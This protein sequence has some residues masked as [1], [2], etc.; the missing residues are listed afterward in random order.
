MKRNFCNECRQ[1][2]D[3][4][5]FY[6]E[7]SGGKICSDCLVR[8]E[9]GGAEYAGLFEPRGSREPLALRRIE[10]EVAMALPL[11]EAL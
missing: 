2:I 1:Q 10:S 8:V 5:D 9:P 4:Q 7:Y 6:M 11:K 3:S